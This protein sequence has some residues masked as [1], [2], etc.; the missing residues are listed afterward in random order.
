MEYSIDIKD[1][2]P[3]LYALASKSRF[4]IELGYR[5]GNGSPLAFDKGL[6]D[7]PHR[8]KLYVSVDIDDSTIMWK[9]VYM[10]NRWHYILGDSLSYDTVDRVKRFNFGE[11]D[12]IFFDTLHTYEHVKKEL[13][14]WNSIAGEKTIFLIHDTYEL[15][16]PSP[17]IF[18]CEEFCKEHG[19]Q[20]LDINKENNGLGMIIRKPNLL[21]W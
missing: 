13:E 15:G 11:P 7:S 6:F 19:Y 17:I 8:D 2:L 1:H 3:F 20:Y 14:V 21:R 5:N 18:S 10:Y 12:I 16:P 4:I 9:P